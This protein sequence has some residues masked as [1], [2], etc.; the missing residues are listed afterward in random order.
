VD[1]PPHLQFFRVDK[2]P[3]PTMIGLSNGS[4]L[5][6]ASGITVKL[7]QPTVIRLSKG[8]DVVIAPGNTVIL[9][10]PTVKLRP[11]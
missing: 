11:I 10:Q 1:K 2:T 7:T 9:T 8:S 5:V 6:I 4:E 3:Q